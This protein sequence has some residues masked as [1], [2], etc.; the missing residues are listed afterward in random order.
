M[1]SQNSKSTEKFKL[2][3]QSYL[4]GLADNDPLFA[5][6]LKKESKNIDDCITYILNTVQKSG[7]SGFTDDEVFSMAVHY[8]DE[9]KI[10]IGKPME[11]FVVQNHPIELTE[12]EIKEARAAAVQELVTKEMN[13]MSK[14]PKPAE[15]KPVVNADPTP[16]LF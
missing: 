14:Q 6:T 2:T 7:A 11:C 13:R 8:Y 10:D 4:Q 16:S 9:D 5:E 12:E 1:K 15:K 3:I